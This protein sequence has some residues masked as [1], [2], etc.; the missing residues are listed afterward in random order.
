MHWTNK[1]IVFFER[2]RKKIKIQLKKK[3]KI[4]KK[5]N[6]RFNFTSLNQTYCIKFKNYGI[7]RMLIF[8]E[9]SKYLE[10]EKKLIQKHKNLFEIFPLPFQKTNISIDLVENKKEEFLEFLP[11]LKINLNLH[12]RYFELEVFSM[13][14]I[15][16]LNQHYIFSQYFL[17]KKLKVFDRYFLERFFNFTKK[18]GLNFFFPEYIF[19]YNK[20][21]IFYC[22]ESKIKF[23]FLSLFFSNNYFLFYNVAKTSMIRISLGP[24]ARFYLAKTK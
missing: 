11:K 3:N 22:N 20:S 15:C 5:K 17:L 2:W 4:I 24:E 8:D 19:S 6:L 14:K 13:I 1:K 21:K 7:D 23:Y 16:K 10:S 9:Q 18:K 12:E